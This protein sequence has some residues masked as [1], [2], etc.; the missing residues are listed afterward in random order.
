M[1]KGKKK[2][3]KSIAI[4]H[5]SEI[6]ECAEE[7]TNEI[8]ALESIYDT[9]FKRLEDHESYQHPTFTITIRVPEKGIKLYFNFE[10][11]LR[12]PMSEIPLFSI[13][14]YEGISCFGIEHLLI[15]LETTC[16][17][18]L[19]TVM[20]H[21]MMIEIEKYLEET[22]EKTTSSFFEEMV[23]RKNEMDIQQEQ[24]SVVAKAVEESRVLLK[25]LF[26]VKFNRKK[27]SKKQGIQK[28]FCCKNDKKA[29]MNLIYYPTLMK[30]V[31]VIHQT[32]IRILIVRNCQTLIRKV[33][34]RGTIR[35]SRKWNY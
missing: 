31:E 16:H 33:D 35:I 3:T 11:P 12:Y 1:G 13:T 4:I 23:Q 26:C 10:F 14:E 17:G 18:L 6:D 24:A 8:Y 34:I 32:Q 27:N 15:Q 28:C 9:D 22:D 5:Q 7:Q 29:V 2:K 30:K 20:I 21:H 19:G 25:K